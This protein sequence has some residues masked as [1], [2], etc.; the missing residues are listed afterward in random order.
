MLG[1]HG[2]CST[3]QQP[4]E[5]E[6]SVNGSFIGSSFWSLQEQ[7]SKP[8]ELLSHLQAVVAAAD[9]VEEECE[10]QDEEGEEDDEEVEGV[11]RVE[12]RVLDGLPHR[13][14]LRPRLVRPVGELHVAHLA[15]WLFGEVVRFHG[16]NFHQGY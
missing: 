16:G 15:G 14:V 1:Q 7:D 4:E 13:G 6:I 2:S 12:H 11:V 9:E 10:R 8:R 5:P 3:A